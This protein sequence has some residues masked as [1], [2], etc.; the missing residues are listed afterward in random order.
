MQLGHLLLA[1]IDIPAQLVGALVV[2]VVSILVVVISRAFRS[3]PTGLV[4]RPGSPICSCGTPTKWKQSD[5][6]WHC[7]PEN[8]PV[9]RPLACQTCNGPGRWLRDSNAWGCDNCRVLIAP[10]ASRVV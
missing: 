2:L 1:H 7:E 4:A 5:N 10:V 9:M 3:A 8:V 6:H